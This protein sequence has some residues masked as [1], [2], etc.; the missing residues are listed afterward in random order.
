MAKGLLGGVESES[1]A[2]RVS[3]NPDPS[4]TEAGSCKLL[5]GLSWELFRRRKEFWIKSITRNSKSRPSSAILNPRNWNASMK[6]PSYD[7]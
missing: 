1:D 4:D 7:R 3:R 5:S 2:S 6:A